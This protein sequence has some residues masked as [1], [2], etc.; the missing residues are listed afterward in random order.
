MNKNEKKAN[1]TKKTP[2]TL[3]RNDGAILKASCVYK[4]DAKLFKIQNIDLDE[5]KISKKKPY[6]KAHKAC[7]HFVLY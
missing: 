5:M 2:N 3:E 6:N 1:E 4:R 7:K